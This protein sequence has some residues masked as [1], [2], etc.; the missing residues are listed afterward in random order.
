MI[1]ASRGRSKLRQQGFRPPDWL[2]LLCGIALFASAVDP[3]PR[4]PIDVV[5][6]AFFLSFSIVIGIM[7]PTCALIFGGP[8]VLAVLRVC[9]LLAVCSSLGAFLGQACGGVFWDFTVVS[10]MVNGLLFYLFPCLLGT[11]RRP[12]KRDGK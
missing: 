6:G 10:G 5:V 3:W 1:L 7:G 12:R 2:L 9:G 4:L 8:W 11:R